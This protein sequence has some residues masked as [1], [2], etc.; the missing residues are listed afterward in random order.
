MKIEKINENKIK[1]TVNNSDLEKNNL[2][3]HSFM[4][5]SI[6]S[7]CLFL[8]ILDKA[9]REIGF[10][11][12]NYKLSI[13]ALALSNGNFIITVTRIN[14]ENLK[15]KRVQAYR[16]SNNL[17]KQKIIYHFSNF[18]DFCNFTNF[19]SISSPNLMKQI[20]P[21]QLLYKYDNSFFFILN[22]INNESIHQI[23]SIIS[24]FANLIENSDL[25]FN[26][27]KEYGVLISSNSIPSK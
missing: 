3:I 26:K 23:T 21:T 2:D 9:E 14:K 20:T 10:D 12:D 7:Q 25:I 1:V 6:E 15:S 18:D 16:K 24:E 5:N 22:N 13:E 8:G 4:S 19:L 17:N 11:T 27:I